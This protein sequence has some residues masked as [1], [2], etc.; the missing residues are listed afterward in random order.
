MAIKAIDLRRGMAVNHKEGIWIC[1]DNQKVAKGNWRSYQV[2]QLKNIK[3]GQLIEDRFRT[4]EG[5]EQ[6]I[7]DRK[8][9]EYLFTEGTNAIL[10]DTDSYE[11]IPLDMELLGDAKKFLQPNIEIMVALLDGV[12]VTAEMPNTVELK[13][14]DT[15]PEVK[16]ATVT[17]V[18]KEAKCEG[19]AVVKV[20]QF[21]KIGETIRIDTR[22]GEYTGRAN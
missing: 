4:D 10:M 21:I 12:P 17:N 8:P 13:V 5:F 9:M 16:G 18:G 22:T 3:T 15:P 7:L 6:A 19:G 1:V 20:P 2:I 14:I 11:Q